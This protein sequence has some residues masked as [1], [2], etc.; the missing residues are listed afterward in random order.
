MSQNKSNFTWIRGRATIDYGNT[1]G[2]GAADDQRHEGGD[3]G[4]AERQ[5]ERAGG[6]QSDLREV[7]SDEDFE[8]ERGAERADFVAVRSFFCGVGRVRSA[9]GFSGG[10]A[11][12]GRAPV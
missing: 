2:D 7:R 12:T 9:G 6:G 3:P 1:R 4:N 11:Y 8:G 5:G 10:E